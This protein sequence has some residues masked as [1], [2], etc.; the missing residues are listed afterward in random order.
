MRRAKPEEGEVLVAQT[1]VEPTD[2][3]VL[4]VGVVVAVLRA[5]HLV[6][7]Q[8]HRH[9][10]TQRERGE[11]VALLAL[12]QLPDDGVVGLA[13]DAVVPRAVVI[14]A[15]LAVLAVGLVVLFVVADQ[16]VQREAV[17]RGNEVDR[18]VRPP[19]VVLVEVRASR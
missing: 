11:E 8:K 14:L 12:A 19:A 17:V 15:V 2:L 18:R 4:A 6:P 16:I 13:L 9:A 10:L 3:V 7:A 5:A 1:P